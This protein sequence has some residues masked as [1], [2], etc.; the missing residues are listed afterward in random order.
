[1]LILLKESANVVASFGILTE[2]AVS[3]SSARKQSNHPVQ[4][5]PIT[6]DFET[7]A[8]GLPVIEEHK[9]GLANLLAALLKLEESHGRT[10]VIHLIPEGTLYRHIV[11]EFSSNLPE[12]IAEANLLVKNKHLVRDAVEVLNRFRASTPVCSKC[13]K[14][15]LGHDG[16]TWVT[17]NVGD[18][19]IHCSAVIV[20]EVFNAKHWSWVTEKEESDACPRI[21]I[22]GED[23]PSPQGEIEN[24]LGTMG[25]LH[26]DIDA[27]L[28]QHSVDLPHFLL[29]LWKK[30]HDNTFRDERMRVLWAVSL[31]KHESFQF[32]KANLDAVVL[33]AKGAAKE[34]TTSPLPPPP[35]EIPAM[36]YGKVLQRQAVIRWVRSFS[37]VVL[38][39]LLSDCFPDVQVGMNYRLTEKATALM[40][41]KTCA[42]ITRGIA[43][44]KPEHFPGWEKFAEDVTQ[45]AIMQDSTIFD[46]V[47][48]ADGAT[49]LKVRLGMRENDYT[50]VLV[51]RLSCLPPEEVARHINQACQIPYPY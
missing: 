26:P 31:Q 9:E 4:G 24:F 25:G 32:S 37:E 33:K 29:A 34:K 42:E 22:D 11:G 47:V 5:E 36:P 6:M 39:V 8:A 13:H 45:A 1:M 40:T 49:T 28:K 48:P 21:H 14:L 38:D 20:W 17:R 41:Y 7:A 12:A 50:H 51:S 3:G 19:C 23:V 43:K 10:L 2:A 30:Y 35:K 46:L 18:R 16:R 15:T 27:L 44:N